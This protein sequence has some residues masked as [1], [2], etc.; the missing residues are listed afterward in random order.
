ML[1]KLVMAIQAD[2]EVALPENL[3]ALQKVRSH[4]LS[5]LFPS[6]RIP[7]TDGSAP[8]FACS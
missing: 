4:R 2:G 3:N 1:D 7:P 6:L 8:P 5:T